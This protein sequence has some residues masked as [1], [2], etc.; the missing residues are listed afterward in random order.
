[1]AADHDDDKENGAEKRRH[2]RLRHQ[3]GAGNDAC[4]RGKRSTDAEHQH[5]DAP[6]IVSEMADHV[7]V[8]EGGLNDHADPGPL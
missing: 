4:D 7:R 3:R 5:E 2:A 1:M 6:D 8:S